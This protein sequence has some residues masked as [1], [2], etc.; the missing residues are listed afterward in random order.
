MA[1]LIGFALIFL[2]AAP[3]IIL[4]SKGYVFD[5]E[6]R[7]FVQTGALFLKTVPQDV[8][9]KIGPTIKT[10]SQQGI[11]YNGIFVRNLIPK[12]YRIEVASVQNPQVSWAKDLSVHPLV[13]TKE[14][15]IALP[16]PE[17]QPQTQ[18]F[19]TT[20]PAFWQETNG[21]SVLFSMDNR[22]IKRLD[23]VSGNETEFADLPAST[24]NTQDP[25]ANIAVSANGDQAVVKTKSR[26]L[27]WFHGSFL[28]AQPYLATFMKNEGAQFSGLSFYWHPSQN[29]TLIVLTR[30]SGYLLDTQ[31]NTYRKFSPTKVLGLGSP[32][33]GSYYVAADGSVMPLA[34]QNAPAIVSLEQWTNTNTFWTLSELPN[35]KILAYQQ[36]GALLLLDGAAHSVTV[37][38]SRVALMRV[39]PDQNRVAYADDNNAVSVTFLRDVFDDVQYVKGQTI[40]LSREEE[41]VDALFFTNDTWYVAAAERQ[42]IAVMEIDARTPI[43]VWH[44]QIP[45]HT[46][47]PYLDNA[48][49]HW[50]DGGTL[51]HADL[52]AH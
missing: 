45:A 20:T 1:M 17:F 24:P 31:S 10:V 16:V 7:R 6:Q 28:N 22:H 34:A 33:S 8:V 43:N 23:L 19:A 47:I 4:Y 49:C 40:L 13:V 18:I 41:P 11:L 35:D 3:V 30:S 52:F 2:C 26:T 44:V 27:F 14:T 39:S 37:L 48:F 51:A 46:S 12:T 32:G 21:S 29:Q 25:I 42:R 38:G 9:M 5:A 50:A 36:G 15:R